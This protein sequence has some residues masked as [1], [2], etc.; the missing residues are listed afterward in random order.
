LQ[1]SVAPRLELAVPT[2]TFCLPEKAS[3]EFPGI[4]ECVLKWTKKY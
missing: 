4:A 2:G 3:K 1:L